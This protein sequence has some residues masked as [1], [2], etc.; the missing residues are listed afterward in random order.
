MQQ[1]RAFVLVVFVCVCVYVQRHTDS[2]PC[3]QALV[4]RTVPGSG[5]FRISAT[6]SAS[7]LLETLPALTECSESASSAS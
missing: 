2:F 6:S 5:L 4:Q 7:P 1:Q 3:I